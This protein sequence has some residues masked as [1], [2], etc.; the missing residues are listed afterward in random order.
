MVQTARFAA[1]QAMGAPQR[2]HIPGVDER[3]VVC[4]LALA[5]TFLEPFVDLGLSQALKCPSHKKTSIRIDDFNIAYA[6]FG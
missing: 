5:T 4:P 2:G 1:E 3:L 6:G